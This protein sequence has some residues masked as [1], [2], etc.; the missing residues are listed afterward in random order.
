MQELI[1]VVIGLAGLWLGTDFVIKGALNIANYYQLS[2]VFVGIAVLA[3]G[4]DLPEMIISIDASVQSLTTGVDASGIVIGNAI[5]SSIAQISLV[6]GIIGLFSYLTLRKKHL[7]QDGLMLLGS[8]LLVLLLGIDGTI[9]LAEGLVLLVV[10]IVYYFRLFNNER[11]GAKVKSKKPNGGLRKDILYLLIGLTIVFFASK[12]AVHNALLFTES[13]GLTHSFVG[14]IVIGLGTSL[15]ELAVSFAAVRK[16]AG[17]LSVG[18]LI[19][20]NIF[21]LLVPVG[22]GASIS[23]IKVDKM[24]V[25]FDL[26]FLFVLSFLVLFFFYKKKGIQRI[27]AVVLVSIY[28]IYCILKIFG[29]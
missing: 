12:F 22:I 14:I 11:V 5:G 6:I 16:K 23:E 28:V 13:Q 26:P 24:L 29:V 7:Y 20:S 4:T 19:G 8:I 27:E 2:Q 18:N 17:G 9:S 3:I 10:Y 25:Y 1:F 21:D 15:P